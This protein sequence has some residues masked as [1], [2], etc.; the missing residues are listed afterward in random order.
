[1]EEINNDAQPSGGTGGKWRG[2]FLQ[3]GAMKG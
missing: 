2:S 1:M 3:L